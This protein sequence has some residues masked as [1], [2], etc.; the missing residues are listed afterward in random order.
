[1][2]L[3]D[4]GGCG[5]RPAFSLEVWRRHKRPRLA[6]LVAPADDPAIG[7]Y[8]LSRLESPAIRIADLR[9]QGIHAPVVVG[10]ERAL[11]TGRGVLR[12]ADDSSRCV[13]CLCHAVTVARKNA[14]VIS[15]SRQPIRRGHFTTRTDVAANRCPCYWPPGCLLA[16][17]ASRAQSSGH[18]PICALP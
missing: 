2:R 7:V 3:V 14:Q 9:D 8:S 4:P 17:F 12:I 11:D 18:R 5:I 10:D 16:K 1:M 6:A 13:N 15:H